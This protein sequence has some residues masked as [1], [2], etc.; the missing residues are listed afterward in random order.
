[1]KEVKKLIEQF[2]WQT[3]GYDSS[4]NAQQGTTGTLLS[5]TT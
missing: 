5:V 1:L 4:G 3:Q 2:L